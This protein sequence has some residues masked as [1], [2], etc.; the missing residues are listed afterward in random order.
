MRRKR[1]KFEWRVWL[2]AEGERLYR[3]EEGATLVFAAATFFAL[4]VAIAFVNQV[5]LVSADR[6]QIQGAADSAAYSGAL[7]EANSLNAIGQ[8]NDGLAYV[9][10]IALRHLLDVTVYAVTLEQYTWTQREPA[11][12]G[13]NGFVIMGGS[14]GTYEGNA[15][16]DY[17]KGLQDPVHENKD[18]LNSLLQWSWDLHNASRIVAGATPVLVRSTVGEIAELNGATHVGFANDLDKIWSA[19]DDDYAGF[20]EKAYAD[21]EDEFSQALYQ[22]YE[23]RKVRQIVNKVS[24]TVASETRTLPR[25]GWFSKE[26]GKLERDYYQIRICWRKDDWDHKGKTPHSESPYSEFRVGAS[27]NGHWH[28]KHHHLAK[29]P[30]DPYA[31][32]I[33]LEHAGQ[34]PGGHGQPDDDPQVHSRGDLPLLPFEKAAPD[35]AHHR[36]ER[37]KVCDVNWSNQVL[38]SLSPRPSQGDGTYAE[39]GASTSVGGFRASVEK[40]YKNKP[41]P[42]V[43]KEGLL[44]S[45]LTVVTYRPARGLTTLFPASPWGMLAVASAQVGV[46]TSQGVTLLTQ[47]NNG[48]ATYTGRGG[49][50]TIPYYSS[51]GRNEADANQNLFYD[52]P[53]GSEGIQFSARLVPIGREL[54]WHPKEVDGAGIRALIGA[55]AR[56][57]S[58]RWYAAGPIKPNDSLSIPPVDALDQY[59][60][61]ASQ[62]DLKKFWH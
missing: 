27:P 2:R 39:V 61:V 14:G 49:T 31:I 26:K 25:A 33:K 6:L 52:R 19:K 38:R 10:Y 36:V 4:T 5:G 60:R 58:Y 7:V 16:I 48:Q 29:N 22:R 47:L 9:N 30:S 45:A 44:R 41:K 51:S 12:T 15:R 55:D 28:K 59:F 57:G 34:D 11:A 3:D 40:I 1:T 32:P 37:C 50:S 42:L 18:Y 21:A 23:K 17:V 46:E 35:W 62:E 20:S 53:G 54:S 8:I 24:N 43:L 13:S 56:G